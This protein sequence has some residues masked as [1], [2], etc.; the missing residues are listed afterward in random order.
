MIFE[1]ETDNKRQFVCPECKETR[2]ILV[3]KSLGKSLNI[4]GDGYLCEEC[5]D[6]IDKSFQ[7][8]IESRLENMDYITNEIKKKLQLRNI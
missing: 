8:A 2:D 7:D 3:W 5:W 6:K 4:D 1:V